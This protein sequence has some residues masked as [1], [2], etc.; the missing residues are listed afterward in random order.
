MDALIQSGINITLALQASLGGLAPL[1]D[2]ISQLG[3]TEFYLLVMPLIYWTVDP[4]LGIR[5]G[6]LLVLIASLNNI[7]K[8]LLHLPRPYWVDSRI[9][10]HWF[11]PSFGAPS[12]HAQMPLGIWG[13]AAA[14]V[15]KGWFTA[16]AM[17]VLV[18]IGLSRVVLGAH[19]YFDVL[20]G[21][22]I[23]GLLLWLFLRYDRPVSAWLAGLRPG[24]QALL[25]AGVTAV[26]LVLAALAGAVAQQAP[27]PPEWEANA[28]AALG[29]SL[30]EVAS[31]NETI[32]PIGTFF[33][34]GLGLIWLR[35]VGG[36]Q[37]AGSR[38]QKIL[39]FVLGAAVVLVLW[40]GLGAVFPRGTDLVSYAARF[41][42]YA[43]VGLW[44]GGGAPI[45]FVRLGLAGKLYASS[46]D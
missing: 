38:Q 32:T 24:R 1:W 46:N 36:F 22:A 7:G 44:A 45:V 26:L 19:F 3:T 16:L 2:A 34:L 39:R 21:W 37:V 18:L 42:R 17:V 27:F 5:L 29:D 40:Q 35:A 41:L 30:H 14:S 31:L 4:R 8:L 15:R 28:V 10:G 6:F 43:L 9:A 33:G 13:L 23:G 25:V 20:L 11:E 12:G